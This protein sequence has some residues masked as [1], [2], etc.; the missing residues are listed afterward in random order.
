MGGGR[1]GWYQEDYGLPNPWQF[2]K[3]LIKGKG[4]GLPFQDYYSSR[5]GQFGGFT[6]GKGKVGGIGQ[7]TFQEPPG[8]I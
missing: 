6:R 5:I 8:V 7:G 3:I 2:F 4:P 1:I